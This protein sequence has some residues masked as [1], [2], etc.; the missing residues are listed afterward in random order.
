MSELQ[1]LKVDLEALESHYN[2][3][4]EINLHRDSYRTD[5]KEEMYIQDVKRQIASLKQQIRGLENNCLYYATLSVSQG[6][7]G[8]YEIHAETEMDARKLIS[9]HTG[10]RWAFMYEKLEDM[11]QH[12]RIKLGELGAPNQ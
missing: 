1:I 8:Y 12:D 5:H 4:V 9:E 10:N 2:N 6:G 7:P 3:L 11:H